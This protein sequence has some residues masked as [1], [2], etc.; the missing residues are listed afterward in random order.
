MLLLNCSADFSL[1][2]FHISG[3]TLSN[4]TSPPDSMT[5]Y[6]PSIFR[7]AETAMD[8]YDDLDDGITSEGESPPPTP[9]PLRDS[10]VEPQTCTQPASSLGHAS[11]AE[12]ESDEEA[13]TQAANG[14]GPGPQ[15]EPEPAAELGPQPA[16]APQAAADDESDCDG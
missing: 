12:S 9:P 5:R 10:S 14:P 3:I 6:A 1:T 13:G 2:C 15:L 16:A 4:E 11:H 7:F 8:A